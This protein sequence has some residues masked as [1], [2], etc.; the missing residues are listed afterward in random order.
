MTATINVTQDDIDQG[1]PEDCRNCPVAIATERALQQPISVDGEQIRLHRSCH[2]I[3]LPKIAQAFVAN[4]DAFDR[5]QPKPFT[6]EIT[7]PDEPTP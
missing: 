1:R 7:F 5:D 6:F 4:F 3:R 2:F